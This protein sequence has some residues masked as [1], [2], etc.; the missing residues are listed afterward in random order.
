VLHRRRSTAEAPEYQSALTFVGA[1]YGLLLGLLVVFAVGHYNDVQ[2]EAQKEASSLVS[3]YDATSVYPPET[4]EDVQHDLICYMRSVAQD[5][6]PSMA[7]GS[8]LE[9]SRTLGFGDQ[10]RADLRTLPDSTPQ[11]GSAYGR[12]NSLMNDASA[13]RQRLLF[14]TVPRIPAA[15]WVVIYAGAFVV[16]LLLAGHYATRPS[17]RISALAAVAVLMTVVVS[18]LA[19]LDHPYGLGVSVQPAQMRHAIT[20]LLVGVNNPAILSACG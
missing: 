20:L 1:S 14:Y 16:T 18:V 4:S 9:A 12:A 19:M 11:Q 3:V 17:G 8:Q 10:V 5:E 7:R 15:L 13:S 2:S 6:W